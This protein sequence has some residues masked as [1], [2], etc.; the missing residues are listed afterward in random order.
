MRRLASEHKI[1]LA[2]VVATGKDGRILKED[3]LNHLDKRGASQT[4]TTA[5]TARAAEASVG[6]PTTTTTTTTKVAVRPEL[7][8]E[9]RS[10]PIKGITKSMFKT[11]TASLSVPHFGLS[12]EI[13]LTKLVKLRPELKRIS[14]ERGTPVSYMPF[15]IK[16]ASLALDHFP[17]LNATIDKG[18]ESITY[19]AAHNIGVAMDT[20]QGLLVPNIK[21]VNHLS[22]L[23]IAQELNRLQE[24]G[25]HGQLGT[26]DLSGGTFTLSNIGSV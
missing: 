18:Q 4:V 7:T 25:R 19:K 22:V 10:E 20:K 17:I 23:Q 13:D 6:K 3:V 21:H 16:A 2:E 26:N 9:D 12:E 15:F 11:M 14:A 5:S 24:L 1:N 8:K